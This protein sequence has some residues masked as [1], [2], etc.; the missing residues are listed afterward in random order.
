MT[1]GN[2]MENN[3]AVVLNSFLCS[4]LWRKFVGLEDTCPEFGCTQ[5]AIR[6]SCMDGRSC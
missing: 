6:F 4:V 3:M 5:G 1:Y 2:R